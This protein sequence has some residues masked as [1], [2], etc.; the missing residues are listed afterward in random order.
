M[1][2]FTILSSHFFCSVSGCCLTSPGL[3][4]FWEMTSPMFPYST[5]SLVRFWI[6]AHASVYATFGW[7]TAQLLFLTSVRTPW[8]LVVTTHP[9]VWV[10]PEVC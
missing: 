8:F 2:S 1:T 6:H 3:L 9:G 4:D 10:L 7:A 5:L